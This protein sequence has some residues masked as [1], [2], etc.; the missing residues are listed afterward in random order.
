MKVLKETLLTVNVS[1][2]FA[3]RRLLVVAAQQMLKCGIM[4]N[5]RAPSQHQCKLVFSLG[6]WRK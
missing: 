1:V 4:E 2:Y 5:M 6:L 3:T